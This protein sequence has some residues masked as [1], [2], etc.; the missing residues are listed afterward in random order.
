MDTVLETEA[1]GALVAEG[2][3]IPETVASAAH[4][5]EL[6]VGVLV[7]DADI[8]GLNVAAAEELGVEDRVVEGDGVEVDV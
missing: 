6:G 3:I 1:T 7:P 2:K 8:V 4:A 5:A